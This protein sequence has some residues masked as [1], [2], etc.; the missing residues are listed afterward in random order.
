MVVKMVMTISLNNPKFHM[1][2]GEH[3]SPWARY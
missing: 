2:K 3:I 1:L